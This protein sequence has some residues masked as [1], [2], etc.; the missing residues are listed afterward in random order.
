[1][2]K[3][4]GTGYWRRVRMFL[5][6][7]SGA[8]KSSFLRWLQGGD[9]LLGRQPDA[10]PIE[11][12]DLRDWKPA[13]FSSDLSVYY[14]DVYSPHSTSQLDKNENAIQRDIT[15]NVWNCGGQPIYYNTQRF[16]YTSGAIYLVVVDLSRNDFKNKGTERLQF[17]IRSIRSH[18]PNASIRIIAT[19]T[20][21]KIEDQEKK[22][23]FQIVLRSLDKMGERRDNIFEVSCNKSGDDVRNHLRSHLMELARQNQVL[24][25]FRWVSFFGNFCSGKQSDNTQLSTVPLSQLKEYMKQTEKINTTIK[26][27]NRINQ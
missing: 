10:S 27:A 7:D 22:W 6:G 11:S 25:P 20:D 5:V 24:C 15:L 23:R 9:P 26:T 8:G 16:F 21:W 1:M 12:I 2:K 14:Q 17:W 4:L 19:H 18:A 3:D 13:S